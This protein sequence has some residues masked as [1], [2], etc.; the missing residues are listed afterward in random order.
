MEFMAYLTIG[1][2]SPSYDSWLL[3]VFKSCRHASA[4][5]SSSNS[6]FF[7]SK[8]SSSYK[9]KKVDCLE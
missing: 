2:P 3:M 7:I 4:S 6:P 9:I 5:S 1:Y 8:L